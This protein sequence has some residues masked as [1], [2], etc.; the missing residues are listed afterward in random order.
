[1]LDW[2]EG[3]RYLVEPPQLVLLSSSPMIF[4]HQTTLRLPFGAS[5]HGTCAVETGSENG[6]RH[7]FQGLASPNP[8]TALRVW[9]QLKAPTTGAS[10]SDVPPAW[11]VSRQSTFVG[12][13]KNTNATEEHDICP[14]NRQPAEDSNGKGMFCD[15]WKH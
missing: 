2:N 13:L 12:P 5:Q 4:Q 3:S 1:M 14:R 10:C 8:G 15:P 7:R 6:S 9:M 11:H